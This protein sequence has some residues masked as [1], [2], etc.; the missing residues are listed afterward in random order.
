[1]HGITPDVVEWSDYNGKEQDLV[2][3]FPK[4]QVG[5]GATLV[6]HENEAAAFFRREGYIRRLPRMYEVFGP[7][8][9]LI[10]PSSLALLT[11]SFSQIANQ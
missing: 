3:Q 7:G 2:W 6:V 10:I 9:H 5:W 1:M 4:K 11:E 8:T